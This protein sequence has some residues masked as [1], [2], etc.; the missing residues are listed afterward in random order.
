MFRAITIML[1]CGVFS[2]GDDAL[3]AGFGYTACGGGKPFWN[4]T[5][6]CGG[7]QSRVCGGQSY[8]F[9]CGEAFVTQ[10][11]SPLRYEEEGPT[12]PIDRVPPAPKGYPVPYGDDNDIDRPKVFPPPPFDETRARARKNGWITL[13]VPKNAK[14]WVGGKLT[15]SKGTKRQYI[16]HALLSD[17]SYRYMVTVQFTDGQVVK[18][19]ILL[20]PGQHKMATIRPIYREPQMIAKAPMRTTVQHVKVEK[21]EPFARLYRTE[22]ALGMRTW[23]SSDRHDKTVAI[24]TISAKMVALEYRNKKDITIILKKENGNTCSA[25]WHWLTS[26]DQEYVRKH[27]NATQTPLIAKK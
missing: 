22:F 9:A 27:Y 1:I 19:A 5:R 4:R 20:K 16:F 24:R 25:D 3:A 7:Q 6:V 2:F 21:I 10:R 17:R 18:K 23:T 26:A 8:Q 13:H 14:V 12:S 15:T 11:S